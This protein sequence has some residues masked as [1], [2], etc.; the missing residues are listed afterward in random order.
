M[1]NE[2]TQITKEAGEKVLH[3]YGSSIFELKEDQSPLTLADQASHQYLTHALPQVKNIPVLSEENPIDRDIRKNW[4][5]FW[6]I[7]PLDGTKEFIH[8]FNDFC[9]NIALIKNKKPVIGLIYAPALNELYYAKED[10]GFQYEG[11]TKKR[12]LSQGLISVTSRFHHSNVTQQFMDLNNI[13][14][15]LTIGAALKF[16]AMALGLIDIYPRFE[17]SKEWDIAA[18]HIILKE[19]NCKIIDLMTNKEPLY[20][21]KYIKNNYFIA[22]H[23]TININKLTYPEFL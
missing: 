10:Y 17:G 3:F 11:P 2:L 5:E 9:I 20:N 12:I 21:K 18:G 22:H 4:D 1:K 23:N 14:N 7:D 19:A 6:L 8:G 15:S 16:G 13:N